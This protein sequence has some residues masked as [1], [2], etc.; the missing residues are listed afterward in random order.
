LER[1]W[2]YQPSANATYKD[3]AL[4]AQD[5]AGIEILAAAHAVRPC[6]KG[7]NFYCPDDPETVMEFLSSIGVLQHRPEIESSSP[8][9]RPADEQEKSDSPLTRGQAAALLYRYLDPARSAGGN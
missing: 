4:Y 7:E 9:S 5:S 1:R 3:V 2:G 6:S 8:A